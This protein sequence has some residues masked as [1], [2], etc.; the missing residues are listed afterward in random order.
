MDLEGIFAAFGERLASGE[1]DWREP[2]DFY[3]LEAE[4]FCRPVEAGSERGKRTPEDWPGMD[5]D[6]ALA[7]RLLKL[8]MDGN[9]HAYGRWL[10]PD[11]HLIVPPDKTCPGM[12]EA[13]QALADALGDGEKVAVYCDY[14]VDGTSAGEILRR[15][16]HPYCQRSVCLDDGE[17]TPGEGPAL[18]FGY[19]DAQRGFG[20]TNEFVERAAAT[21]A[22]MLVTLDCGSGQASQV[23]LAQSLGMRVVVVD[24]HGVGENPAEFHINPKLGASGQCL[25][26][27]EPPTSDNT[28]SQLTWKLAAA[29][30]VACEGQTRPEHW[31]E[32]L[33]LAGMGCIADRASILLHEN[34]AFFW[35][36]HD[37]TVPG[38]LALAEALGEDASI[39]GS[40]VRT[41]A[42]LNLPKRTAKVAAS[43][44]GA[45]FAAAS[46]E[47]AAA[48]VEHLLAAYEESKPAKRAMLDEALRQTGV[49]HKDEDGRLERPEREKHIAV[50]VLGGEFSDYAGQTGPVAQSVSKAVDKPAIVFASKGVDEHGQRLFKFSS[51]NEMN[52]GFE[53]GT[54]LLGDE[55]LT[56]ACTLLRRDESGAA[57]EQAVVGGHA[58]VVSGSCTEEAIPRVVAAFEA[59]AK[60]W[61]EKNRFWPSP[62]SGPD[63]VLSERKVPRE[64]L[65]RLEVESALLAP[66]SRDKQDLVPS[67]GTPRKDRNMP[68]RVSA[69]GTLRDLIQDPERENWLRGTLDLGGGEEREAFFPADIEAPPPGEECEWVLRLD[70][71][72][73]YYLRLFHRSSVPA[74]A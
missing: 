18:L 22:T 58:A 21:G 38:V 20:L 52:N 5:I 28:G 53:L 24:H 10:R 66:F 41:Q 45:L 55:A 27:S 4:Q 54:E 56:S 73:S 49:A 74:Q 26:G 34:R 8:E 25:D 15:G 7:V 50:A 44:V 30:Q 43:D 68:L 65:L 11:K 37:K 62:Y 33:K 61:S 35:C 40:A 46:Y 42:V 69:F 23:R 17:D 13:G 72:R 3:R 19:A 36:A 9:F 59:R 29:V 2:I 47:E 14:D 31:E 60:A 48:L 64:R 71:S 32:A 39:P 6:P 12:M 16:L 70:G 51:R 1:P 57:V 67:G 63:A